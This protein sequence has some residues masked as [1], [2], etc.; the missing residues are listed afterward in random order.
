LE[1]DLPTQWPPKTGSS[2]N[3]YIRQSRLH[4]YIAQRTLHTNKRGNTSKRN[5]NYQSIC[6]QF[7]CPQFHQIYTKGLKSTYRLK[8]SGRRD[9]NTPLPPIDR[10]L[11]QKINKE[12]LEINDT[13]DQMDLTNVYIIFHPTTEQYIFFSAVHRTFSKIDHILGHKASFNKYKKIEITLAFYL[14]TLH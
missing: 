11:K 3:T 8:H 1:K 2:S 4:I 7:Q 13:K 6:T 5:D 12:I 10:S 9:F 14:I